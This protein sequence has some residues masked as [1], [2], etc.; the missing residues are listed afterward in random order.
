MMSRISSTNSKMAS[1]ASGDQY[2]G[3]PNGMAIGRPELGRGSAQSGQGL[4]GLFAS[5]MLGHDLP[6]RRCLPFRSARSL[7]SL[8]R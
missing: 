4:P 1:A 6:P 2:V 5:L 8:A 3:M 7:A